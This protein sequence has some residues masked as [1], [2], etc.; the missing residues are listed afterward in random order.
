M[1]FQY[2]FLIVCIILIGCKK[3]YEKTIDEYLDKN[4]KDPSSY[5]CVELGKP[6]IIT[7]MGIAL[8]EAT[9]RAK[10][11]EF[12]F[13]SISSKLEQAKSYFKSQGT[14]PY[15]TLGWEVSHKYRAKNSYGAYDIQNVVYIFNK[16]MTKIESVKSK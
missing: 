16:D 6:G 14:N 7:P 9:K 3:S 12:P 4:L 2:F 11:G 13:D 5:K 10:A 15:D 8:V 1:K